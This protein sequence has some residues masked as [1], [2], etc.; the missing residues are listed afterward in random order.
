MFVY[1]FMM[2]VC[3]VCLKVLERLQ[4]RQDAGERLRALVLDATTIIIYYTCFV[5]LVF[6]LRS[7]AGVPAFCSHESG[8]GGR[9]PDW[10]SGEKGAILC[11][12]PSTLTRR[13]RAAG[14][15]LG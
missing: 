1:C 13:R 9:A 12:K 4:L 14:G 15:L 2:F 3:Y 10:T 11:L 6:F 8:R 5:F 7:E